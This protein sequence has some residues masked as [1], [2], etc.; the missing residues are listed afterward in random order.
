MT[1]VTNRIAQGIS[2]NNC[3]D[4]CLGGLTMSLGERQM[5]QRVNILLGWAG[6]RESARETPSIYHGPYLGS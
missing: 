5:A 4:G 6:R 1:G 3:P 2:A